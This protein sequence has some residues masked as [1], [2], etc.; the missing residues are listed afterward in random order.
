[1]ATVLGIVEQSGGV[2]RCCSEQG[3]GTSFRILLPALADAFPTAGSSPAGLV[4]APR[5]TESILLVEDEDTVRSLVRT[6][7]M[8]RG[9]SVIEARNGREGLKLC[10]LHPGRIDLLVTD[11]VMP[12]LG[13]RE[14]AEAALKLRPGLKVVLMSGHTDD[15][16]LKE[17]V[18]RG[19]AFIY[20]PFTPLQ[21]AQKVRA[22]LDADTR[23]VN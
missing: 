5:G 4:T 18:Q 23:T 9:Y 21:L 3:E 10:E 11:V 16:I 8:A 19:V 20:K 22:T 17:G 2:I 14:L 6:I 7:L 1:L 13:G 15:V 12:L